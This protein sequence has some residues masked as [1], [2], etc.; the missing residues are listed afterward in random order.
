MTDVLM[1]LDE[2]GGNIVISGREGPGGP[3]SGD[4]VM[5]DGPETDILHALF[6]GRDDPE[7][8]GNLLGNVSYKSRT[9]MLLE[10]L[11]LTSG[12]IVRIETAVTKDLADADMP[13][14]GEVSISIPQ[15]NRVSIQVGDIV[16]ERDWT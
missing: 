3:Y 4:V 9:Q 11:P 2:D 7:W 13:D 16:I 12:N 15:P 8:W 1:I 14:I 5:T 6:G 10:T